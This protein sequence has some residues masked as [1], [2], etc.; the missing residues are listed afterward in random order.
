LFSDG[1]AAIIGTG[2]YL[3]CITPI[4]EGYG[5]IEKAR[6]V[7]KGEDAFVEAR[8]RSRLQVAT[9]GHPWDRNSAAPDIYCLEWADTGLM[10]IRLD[11]PPERD[12]RAIQIPGGLL[13]VMAMRAGKMHFSSVDEY[14][15][16]LLKTNYYFPPAGTSRN[17]GI[18]W[19]E[20][21]KHVLSRLIRYVENE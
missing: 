16:A 5:A 4:P 7:R 6:R 9:K 3:V 21:D 2:Q 20:T 12:R 11:L 18:P 14:L 19:N 10:R 15:S 8:P 17:S 1:I 13:P